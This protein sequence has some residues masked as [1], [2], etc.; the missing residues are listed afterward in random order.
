MTGAVGD[1]VLTTGRA[2]RR[3]PG[4]AG[5]SVAGA[6]PRARA[7]TCAG[8]CG[9]GGS[10]GG[11]C[12]GGGRH[13]SQIE[14]TRCPCRR[15]ASGRERCRPN[16]QPE[17]ALRMRYGRGLPSRKRPA[18][19]SQSRKRRTGRG[20]EGR[21]YAFPNR[22]PG[23]VGARCLIDDCILHAPPLLASLLTALCFRT[24]RLRVGHK[25]AESEEKCHWRQLEG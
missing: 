20:G 3:L 10:G 18:S 8:H 6:A 12:D 11:G 9:G 21:T 17:G 23:G 15:E 4:H 16:I 7:L 2:G 1:G 14:K 19:R 22:L 13:P 5:V 24:L 25:R